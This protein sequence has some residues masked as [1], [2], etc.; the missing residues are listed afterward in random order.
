M[1]EISGW[2]K[3]K[4]F[5]WNILLLLFVL[6]FVSLRLLVIRDQESSHYHA[7]LHLYINSQ[8][9][10]FDNPSFYEET[11]ACSAANE[12]KPSSRAH[13]HDDVGSLIHVHDQAVTYGHF[14]DN[15]GFGLSDKVL[16]TREQAYVDGMAG[17]LR[18]ILNGKPVQYLANRVIA[19]EDVVLIDWSNDSP[20]LLLERYEKIPRLADEANRLQDPAGC[21]GGGEAPSLWHSLRR[22]LTF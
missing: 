16:E 15:L 14:F 6:W 19:S 12:S 21:A 8:R 7:D 11:S 9:Q 20:A 3:S 18:F 22:S 4:T 17:Q 5:W 2:V 1:K 10:A 13:M